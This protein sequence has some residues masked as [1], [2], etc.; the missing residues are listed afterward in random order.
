MVVYPSLA[1]GLANEHHFFER[2][3][4]HLEYRSRFFGKVIPS[5]V[6]RIGW[7]AAK[8]AGTLAAMRNTLPV[9]GDSYRFG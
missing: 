5:K 2:M 6:G 4:G 8:A 1:T 9:H 7:S 3:R